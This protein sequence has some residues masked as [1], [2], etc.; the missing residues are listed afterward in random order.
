MDRIFDQFAQRTAAA[1]GS[2]WAFSL[3][4]L[5]VVA[6]AI[7]GLLLGYSEAWLLVINTVTTIVTFLMVFLLQNT[8]ERDTKA[9]HLKLDELLRA[10]TDAR[11]GE[12]I[13]MEDRTGRELK[14]AK[15]E[16]LEAIK[17]EKLEACKP[18]ETAEDH[19]RHSLLRRH[20]RDGASIGTSSR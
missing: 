20:A 7:G 17:E 4:A 9:L 2:A 16:M 18:D 3:A 6:W 12:F 15:E 13:D 1:T 11:H 5:I 19:A 10:V 14:V 8:Q